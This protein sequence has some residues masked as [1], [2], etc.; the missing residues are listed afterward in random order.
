MDRVVQL[1]EEQHMLYI[2]ARLP[3]IL[4]VQ[5]A[6]QDVGRTLEVAGCWVEV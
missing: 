3:V 2:A 1:H 6:S 5:S 4:V